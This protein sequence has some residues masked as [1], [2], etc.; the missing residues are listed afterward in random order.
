MAASYTRDDLLASAGE[1][2]FKR[3]EDYIDAVADLRLRGG[4]LHATVY[5]T[6]PYRVRL[7]IGSG[8]LD[9][10]CT[11]SYA[12][13]GAFCEH[14]VAVGLAKLEGVGSGDGAAEEDED[15]AEL[16]DYLE[17]LDHAELVELLLDAAAEDDWL[18]TRLRT[19]AELDPA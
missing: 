3:G 10:D 18:E 9:G 19:E 15:T 13:G 11:C 5:G 1:Q 7:G 8:G 14:L 12:D 6:Q 16:R 2:S 4:A 17:S